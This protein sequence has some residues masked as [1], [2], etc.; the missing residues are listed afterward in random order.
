MDQI[1][2][3]DRKRLPGAGGFTLVEVALSIIV[4]GLIAVAVSSAYSTGTRALDGQVDLVLLDSRLR[5]RME[6]L[7]ST[8]FDTLAGGSENVIVNGKEFTIDWL[9]SNIDLNAD[10]IAELTAKQIM[11]S[12]AGL[13][14]RSLTAIVVDTEG[15]FEKIS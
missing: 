15:Q 2:R 4:L 11:V 9:V 6:L 3:P 1:D 5:S 8:D 10:G 14:N 12:V 13:P 7:V